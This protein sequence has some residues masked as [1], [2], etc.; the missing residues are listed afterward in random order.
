MTDFIMAA[1]IV[2]FAIIGTEIFAIFF[3]KYVMHGIGWSLHRSHHTP[4]KGYFELNDL[5]AFVFALGAMTLFIAGAL[6]WKPLWHAGLG[7]TIYGLLYALVHDGLV[8]RRLPLKF[9]PRRG[10]LKCLVQAHKLHHATPTRDGAVS[11]GFLWAGDVPGLK[12]QL[13]RNQLAGRR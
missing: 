12:K 11:F 2:L 4:R 8:H 3:H 13:K 7:V 1:S 9:V 10:Y 6:F 5:Y